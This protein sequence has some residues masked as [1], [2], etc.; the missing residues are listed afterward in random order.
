[1]AEPTAP[2]VWTANDLL[3]RLQN[4]GRFFVRDV[5]NRSEFERA[6]ARRR[7]SQIR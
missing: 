1:M 4:R 6:A 2:T 7:F 3:E 5:R